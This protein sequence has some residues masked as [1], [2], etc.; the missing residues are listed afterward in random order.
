MDKE[1]EDSTD[2]DYGKNDILARVMGPDKPGRVQTFGL[3]PTPT[4]V[5]GCS[6]ENSQY[7]KKK[8]RHSL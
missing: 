7:E 8:L 3:G 1:A 2:S 5:F 6:H 4:Q